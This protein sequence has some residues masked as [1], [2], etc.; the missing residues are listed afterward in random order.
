[1]VKKHEAMLR[2][3]RTALSR[4]V[5]CAAVPVSFASQASAQP[6]IPSVGDG[7]VSASYQ[8]AFTRG[9]VD[10]TGVVRGPNSTDGHVLLWYVEYG[11]IDRIA[12]HVSLPFMMVRYEGI[13]PHLLGIKGQPSTIDDGT[14]H[15]AFQDFYFGARY[16]LVE[17][18]RLALTPF[19]EAIVPSH[20]Y[21]SAGQ[22]VVGRDLRALVLGA[23]VGGFADDL[24]P[25]LFFQ[26][27]LSYARVQKILN[28]RPNRTSID[29]AVGYFVTPRLAVQLIET[30]Q[31]TH[32]GWEFI[33][34]H[35]SI[36]SRSGEPVT[37]EERLNHDRL[38]RTRVVNLGGG[39]T[40]ALNDSIEI[41]ATTTT[42]VWGKQLQRPRS[43]TLGANWNFH[44]SRTTR[45]SP[46]ENVRLLRQRTSCRIRRSGC[47]V[48]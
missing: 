42:M 18:P 37:G 17:S 6:F 48:S 22:S 44:T 13:N 2:R 45:A 4:L 19:A 32:D 9:Q 10:S 3:S 25:G 40:F 7:T 24:I 5:V 38:M 14:Y 12:V 26:A 1:M 43:V 23:A 8:A 29:S 16:K 46:S 11:L 41:F 33:G 36:R 34:G 39:L 47:M 20:R 21:E 30:F 31:Y 35:N 28:V 27:R 15:G